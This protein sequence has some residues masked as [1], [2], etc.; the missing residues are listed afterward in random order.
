MIHT[1]PLRDKLR[2]FVVLVPW[3]WILPDVIAHGIR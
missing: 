3:F 2:M 1:W